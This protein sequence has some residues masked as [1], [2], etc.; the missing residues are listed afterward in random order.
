MYHP[1][2]RPSQ[3]ELTDALSP[4]KDAV[5]SVPAPETE[6]EAETPSAFISGDTLVLD[7]DRLEVEDPDKLS[8]YVSEVTHRSDT[9]IDTV[10]LTADDGAV[11]VDIEADRLQD[12]CE[13][14][15]ITSPMNEIRNSELGSNPGV[16]AV[17]VYEEVDR[18]LP[19]DLDFLHPHAA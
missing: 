11:V 10:E 5:E 2:S 18:E 7:A 16:A 9:H 15:L 1:D 12:L 6:V 13:L 19:D 14:S 8:R 4:E 3:K 17:Q